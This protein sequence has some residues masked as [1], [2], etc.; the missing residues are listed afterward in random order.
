V[1]LADILT[2]AELIKVL[3]QAGSWKRFSELLNLSPRGLKSI[4][5]E[6]PGLRLDKLTYMT[7]ERFRQE[8]GRLCSVQLFSIIHECRESETRR[9]AKEAGIDLKA[10]RSPG[11]TSTTLTGREGELYF[12]KCCGPYIGE[13][14]FE[15]QGNTAPYDFIHTVAGRVNVKTANASRY[16][17]KSRG[18]SPIY[19]EFSLNGAD[20][21][22]CFAFILKSRTGTFGD[23]LMLKSEEVLKRGLRNLTIRWEDVRPTAGTWI[24]PP[25]GEGDNIKVI[26]NFH[27]FLQLKAERGDKG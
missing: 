26:V 13:D 14:C 21:C 7:H 12:K 25:W 19:W 10:F 9:F 1:A 16:T 8:I 6:Y 5:A 4:R 15:T 17:A 20:K 3:I 2:E 27:R 18:S 23:I 11:A 24:T 22:D